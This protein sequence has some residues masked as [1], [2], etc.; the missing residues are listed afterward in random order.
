MMM[1]PGGGGAGG[2]RPM[3]GWMG[4]GAPVS[5]SKNFHKTLRQLLGRLR[6]ETSW[7]V[8]V[9]ILGSASVAFSVIGP[10]IIGNAMN[11]IFDGIIGKRLPVG[12]TKAQAIALLQSHGQ[13]QLAQMLSGTN[14]VPGK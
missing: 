4:M 9:A 1:R 11:I 13:G 12:M 7:L 2:G 10:R 14:V 3:G 6:P 8:V 5:K